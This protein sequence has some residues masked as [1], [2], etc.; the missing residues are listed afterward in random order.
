MLKYD[1]TLSVRGLIGRSGNARYPALPNYIYS[2]IPMSVLQVHSQPLLNRVLRRVPSTAS[3]FNLQFP[4]LSKGRDGAV[5]IATRYGL[6][7]P[8]IESR[9]GARF[10]HTPPDR[11]CGPPSLLYNG[12]RVS[13]PGVKRLGRGV[14][15]HLHLAPRLKKEQSYTYTPP[16]GL[17]GLFQGEIYFY[18]YLTFR[19]HNQLLMSSSSSSRHFYPSI[20]LPFNNMFQKAVPT[21]DIC[22]FSNLIRTLFT[23]SEG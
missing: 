20:Y 18:L 22:I 1:L 23:V 8:R 7:G 12:Y 3:S 17:R 9:W 16:L 14:S 21:Q 19:F 15:T 4:L 6:D 2:F 10:F 11:P 13:L 5:G